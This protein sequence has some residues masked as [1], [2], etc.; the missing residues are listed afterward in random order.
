MGAAP[1]TGAV[2]AEEVEVLAAVDP[3][4]GN[5]QRVVVGVA[6][7]DVEVAVDDVVK[8]ESLAVACRRV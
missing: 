8:V 5:D 7:A 1:V 3:A 4:A 2:G 6:A